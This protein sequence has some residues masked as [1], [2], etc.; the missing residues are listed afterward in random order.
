VP[1]PSATANNVPQALSCVQRI[2]TAS[3]LMVASFD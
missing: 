2:K 1:T 3:V